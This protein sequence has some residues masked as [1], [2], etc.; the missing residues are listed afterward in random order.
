MKKL[1]FILVALFAFTGCE[2][3]PNPNFYQ[4]PKIENISI[5]PELGSITKDDNVTV[6][7]KITNTY[8]MGYVCV[9]YWV[10]TPKWSADEMP[11]LNIDANTLYQWVEPQEEGAEGKWE[12]V[13]STTFKHTYLYTCKGEGCDF[14]DSLKPS[15]CPNCSGSDFASVNVTCPANKPIEFVTKIP[16]QSKGKFVLFHIYCVD[17]YG[18]YNQSENFT[19]TV[20]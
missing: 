6:S 13:P 14:E 17:D 1:I 16:K 18:L 15:A 4:K 20:Q 19:Y 10:C 9:K 7:A 2:L 3:D 8:G 12:K 5:S 11:V